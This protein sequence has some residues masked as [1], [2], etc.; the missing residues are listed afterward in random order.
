[1]SYWQERKPGVHSAD[2]GFP[3]TIQADAVDGADVY[4]LPAEEYP[5]HVKVRRM[6]KSVPS[7]QR[8][9]LLRT[10]KSN[11]L[12]SRGRL[13]KWQIFSFHLCDCHI[14]YLMTCNFSQPYMAPMLFKRRVINEVQG[15]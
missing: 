4:S 7:R 9:T 13:A 2:N 1:M 6:G 14:F 3:C 12:V 8:L 10:H 11:P 5:G 15:A